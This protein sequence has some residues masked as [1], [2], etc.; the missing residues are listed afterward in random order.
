MKNRYFPEKMMSYHER[1]NCGP[2]ET[3]QGQLDRTFSSVHSQA[4]LGPD[5]LLWG[6]D[7]KT[8]HV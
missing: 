6:L 5:L 7:R 8:G 4:L 1:Y 3:C 2:N